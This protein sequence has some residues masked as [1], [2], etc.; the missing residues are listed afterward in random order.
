MPIASFQVRDFTVPLDILREVT[1]QEVTVREVTIR[2]VTIREAT[3]R[4]VTARTVMDPAFMV[5]RANR[6][7][8]VLTLR[9]RR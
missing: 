3:I 6:A 8:T 5:L 4:P 2:P 7:L 9:G 1:V